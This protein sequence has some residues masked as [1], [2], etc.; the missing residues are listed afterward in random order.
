MGTKWFAL[1]LVAGGCGG[2]APIATSDEPRRL[3]SQISGWVVTGLYADSA[4]VYVQ[5]REPSTGWEGIMVA[6][7]GRPVLHMVT[8]AK[9]V[10]Y[11]SVDISKDAAGIILTPR[12]VATPAAC[13]VMS[14]LYNS[15][16]MARMNDEAKRLGGPR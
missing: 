5:V 2:S 7:V 15:F 11:M 6:R 4:G 14:V 9:Q 13:R 10:C 12:V 3:E 8:T 1:V 16:A